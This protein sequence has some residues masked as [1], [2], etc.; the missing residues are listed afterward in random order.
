MTKSDINQHNLRMLNYENANARCDLTYDLHVCKYLRDIFAGTISFELGQDDNLI[1]YRQKHPK[2]S[3][4]LTIEAFIY[5]VQFD[6]SDY[7]IA[8]VSEDVHKPTINPIRVKSRAETL[9]TR[10]MTQADYDH[11]NSAEQ[12]HREAE[13]TYRQALLHHKHLKKISGS[14]ENLRKVLDNMKIFLKYSQ[15][16]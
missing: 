10:C 9:G 11:K 12:L 1:I 5:F 13:Q 6:V 15:R 14:V 16:I 7:M 3:E 4:E 8:W 2:I